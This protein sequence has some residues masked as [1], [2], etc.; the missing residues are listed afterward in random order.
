MLYGSNEERSH[1]FKRINK[2]IIKDRKAGRFII[3]GAKDSN[4]GG[5][6]E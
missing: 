6:H 5:Q 4:Y 2:G 1:Y 3:S